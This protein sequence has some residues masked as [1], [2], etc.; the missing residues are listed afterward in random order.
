MNNKRKKGVLLV[1]LG[2]PNAPSTPEV[3]KYLTQFLMDGRVLDIPTLGRNLLVRGVIVPQRAAQSAETYAT[4]WDEVNG[5]PLMYY[6]LLQQKMLQEELGDEFHVELA[7][8]YQN[9]SIE[10]ALKKMQ[11]MYL[12]SIK[13]IPLF[14]Q[15]A[16][17]T[18]G[19]VIDKV[20]EIMRTWQYIPKVSFVS[21]YCEDDLMIETYAEH[22][23]RHDITSFD[24]IMFSYH[25]LPVRQLGKVDPKGEL[26][27]PDAG[28]DTCKKETNP[29]CYLS[30][31]Y[32]TS[33]AIASKIGIPEDRYT[34]CFQSRLGKTPWI[35]PY[36]SDSLH[37]LA[38]KGLKRLLVFSPAFVSD[39][40]ETL[41]EIQVEYAEEFKELGGEEVVMVESLNDD[42]K[43]I[44][45]LKRLVLSN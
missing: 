25:G 38:N 26:K 31:C 29:F 18:S 11:E 17:A 6:S 35:Q 21:S 2:T 32:A 40:I 39:C 12:E 27:C 22:G 34:V 7:M 10:S 42:P 36:T 45:A 23:K 41:D 20:M 43:W 44:Q 37:D 3:R 13:V 5:S 1:Q 9:P 33:R 4:I 19:S 16:S 8:R 24:H 28:C 15:Y 30:Q 14:P